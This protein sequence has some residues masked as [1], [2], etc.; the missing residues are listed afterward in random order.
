MTFSIKKRKEKIWKSNY[1]NLFSLSHLRL[2]IKNTKT[3]K[4]WN[5]RVII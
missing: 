4:E 3:K 1:L 5:L 2:L